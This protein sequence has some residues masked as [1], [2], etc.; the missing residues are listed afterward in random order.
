MTRRGPGHL[1]HRDPYAPGE[2]FA[3]DARGRYG[4][5]VTIAALLALLAHNEPPR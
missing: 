3:L 2:Q 1:A 5:D 4:P